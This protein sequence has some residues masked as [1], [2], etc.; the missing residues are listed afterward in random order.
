[1]ST[2]IIKKETEALSDKDRKRLEKALMK[3]VISNIESKLAPYMVKNK[4]SIKDA[5]AIAKVLRNLY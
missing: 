4:T 3:V 5:I 1:M 2:S